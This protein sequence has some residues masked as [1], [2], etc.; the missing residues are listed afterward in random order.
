MLSETTDLYGSRLGP[1]NTI[2]HAPKETY[3]TRTHAKRPY[4]DA[5]APLLC[6][7]G[8]APAALHKSFSIWYPYT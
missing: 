6:V 2:V 5:D 4:T 1:A 8:R 7:V 3:A